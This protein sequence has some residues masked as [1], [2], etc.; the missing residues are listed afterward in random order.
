MKHSPAKS[1]TVRVPATI[2]NLGSGF[3]SIGIAVD[4]WNT[5][6]IE[7]GDFKM[8]I[9]GRGSDTLPHDA[10][11]LL[12]TGVL[13]A[14][15]S[16]GIDEV[17]MPSL[18]YR[19][20]QNIPIGSGLGSSSAA[21]VA[22]I[23]AGAAIVGANMSQTQIVKLAADIE[24]HAD[25]VAP[26]IVGG[27]VIGVHTNTDWIVD[28]VNV[29]DG[30][31]FVLFCPTEEVNTNA[32]RASLPTAIA[33][34]DVVYNLGRSMLLVNALNK[35]DLKSLKIATQDRLHQPYRESGIKGMNS[36]IKAA[37]EGGALCAF[38]AGSGPTTAALT[39]EKQMTIS[40]EMREA[41][42]LSGVSGDSLI[43]YCSPKGAHIVSRNE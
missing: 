4:L 11:N 34:S 21:I 39:I 12:A 17:D 43:L 6:T 16:L 30:L 29:P 31:T 7:R 37:L 28:S 20:E 14:F 27:C 9:S 1:V 2:A 8:E 26:A 5:V 32:S 18:S 23:M 33:M 3:D 10:T 13:T 22:G 24:G 25:N 38:L 40:Y 19:A 42:R 41:A 36:I 35:G 15:R